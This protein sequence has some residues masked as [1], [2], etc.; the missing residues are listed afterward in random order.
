MTTTDLKKYIN[1]AYAVETMVFGNSMLESE[2]LIEDEKFR[3]MPAEPRLI[4]APAEPINKTPAT[5]AQI[6]ANHRR[7]VRFVLAA[8]AIALLAA[9]LFILVNNNFENIISETSIFKDSY[10]KIF[11]P[12]AILLLSLILVVFAIVIFTK[13]SKASKATEIYKREMLKY[14]SELEQINAQNVIITNRFRETMGHWVNDRRIFL[15]DSKAK[16]DCIK[17][18]SDIVKLAAARFYEKNIIDPKYRNLAAVSSFK[19]YFES[20]RCKELTGAYG[21]YSIYD[22]ECGM[23]SLKSD[24]AEAYKDIESVKD[25]Q[26]YLYMSLSVIK[27]NNSEL[28]TK[29]SSEAY[30]A[31]RNSFDSKCRACVALADEIEM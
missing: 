4:P 10:F 5:E 28:M 7:A 20:G 27:K 3:S 13:N 6:S 31:Y 21:A 29:L 17:E 26:Q 24:A 22:T 18:T 9:S 12:L 23:K 19:D 16:I 11:A 30:K 2:F 8:I 15:A 14:Q 25:K 1:A